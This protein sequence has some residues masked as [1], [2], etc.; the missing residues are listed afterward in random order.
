MKTPHGL[1]GDSTGTPQGLHGLCEDSMGGPHGLHGGST[2][3]PWGLHEDS[4]RTVRTPRGLHGNPWGTVKYSIFWGSRVFWSFGPGPVLPNY[5][6]PLAIGHVVCSYITYGPGPLLRML[7]VTLYTSLEL[8]IWADQ[9]SSDW[10]GST[11]TRTG[12][13]RRFWISTLRCLI[14]PVACAI[15]KMVIVREKFGLLR[16]GWFNLY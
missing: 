9:T 7:Q 13:S 8:P 16:L 4:V 15:P 10:D 14:H 2:G 5:H 6:V 3:T 12:F 11:C 1:H